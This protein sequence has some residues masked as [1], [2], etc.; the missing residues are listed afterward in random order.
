MAKCKALTGSAFKGLRFIA[1]IQRADWHCSESFEM[2]K[3]KHS[4][5]TLPTKYI[6]AFFQH[7]AGS[8]ET[9][10]FILSE[11]AKRTA[12]KSSSNMRT[13]HFS[14]IITARPMQSKQTIANIIIIIIVLGVQKKVLKNQTMYKNSIKEHATAVIQQNNTTRTLSSWP[15][16]SDLASR[17]INSEATRRCSSN[18]LTCLL[19]TSPSPRDS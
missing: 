11:F 2:Y 6:L 12:C 7:N 4:I 8:R 10:Q 16:F 5:F 9:V 1:P 15:S 13:G 19:Y 17:T 18:W 3:A 14:L